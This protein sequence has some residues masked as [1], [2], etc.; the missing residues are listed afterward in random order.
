M[1]SYQKLKKENQ[2]LKRELNI[3]CSDDDK[4]YFDKQKIIFKYN[5]YRQME[6]AIMFG[7]A[8]N[9]FKIDEQKES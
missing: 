5:A 6:Q 4:L 8:K 9:N 2:E 7:N 1:T 3:L